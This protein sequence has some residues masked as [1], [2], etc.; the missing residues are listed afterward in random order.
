MNSFYGVIFIVL[1]S[2]LIA[3]YFFK[4]N[5]PV[6]KITAGVT[7]ILVGVSLF[8]N[9]TK[10]ENSLSFSDK[11]L[12]VVTPDKQY[13]LVFSKGAID[14]TKVLPQSKGQKVKINTVFS[15]GTIY[16]NP[17]TPILINTNSVLA[18]TEMPDKNTVNLG[19]VKYATNSFNKDLNYLEIEAK[20]IFGK[21]EI[22]EDVKSQ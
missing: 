2:L 17:Q 11:T 18:I 4:V 13:D 16:I 9:E 5:I 7:L 14:L 22:I 6:F 3:R 8:L 20:V 15:T 12:Q 19:K 10:S 1:G 21:L